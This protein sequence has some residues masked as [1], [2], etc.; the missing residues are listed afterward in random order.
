MSPSHSGLRGSEGLPLR[1]NTPEHSRRGGPCRRINLRRFAGYPTLAPGGLRKPLGCDFPCN[2]EIIDTAPTFCKRSGSFVS[3]LIR[4]CEEEQGH[5]SVRI[6]RCITGGTALAVGKTSRVFRVVPPLLREVFKT[7][8]R[9]LFHAIPH[10]KTLLPPSTGFGER[11]FKFTR[12][13]GG[14]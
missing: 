12:Q 10:L 1:K 9:L 3:P 5:P 13:K 14:R 8:Q 4:D 11:Y 7:S 6:H 2:L